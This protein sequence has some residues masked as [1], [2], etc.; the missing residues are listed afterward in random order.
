MDTRSCNA[1]TYQAPSVAE[2]N[3]RADSLLNSGANFIRLASESYATLDGRT[4]GLSPQ[5]D[6]AYLADLVTIVN[7]IAQKPDTYVLLS[8]WAHP[9]IGSQGRPTNATVDAWKNLAHAFAGNSRVMFGVVNEPE[10]NYDGSGDAAVWNLMNA[11]VQGIRAQETLDGSPPHLVA[12]Q[13]TGGWARLTQYYVTHPIPGGNVVYETHV[14]NPQSDFTNLVTT[15]SSTLPLIIGEFGPWPSLMTTTDTQALI[16]LA[17]SL[18]V[19]WAAW[20]MHMRCDPNLLV[21]NS[22][23][24]CGIGM[25]LAPTAWGQQIQQNFSPLRR[26]RR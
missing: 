17:N 1:C 3:R 24:G 11:V 9:S 23:W 14:Y 22:A 16:D 13:G 12:V 18:E 6:P 19:P 8:L 5:Q 26:T 21:D 4:H 2:V 10:N 20:T 15:P 25:T 7:H